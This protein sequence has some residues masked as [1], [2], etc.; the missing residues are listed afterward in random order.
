MKNI[1]IVIGF[2]ILLFIVWA[3]A[4]GPERF[5]NKGFFLSSPN[6]PR[7][8][9]LERS[10]RALSDTEGQFFAS[11]GEASPLQEKLFFSK[12]TTG[13]REIDPKDEYVIIEASRSNT[14]PV[15]IS[16]MRLS[17]PISGKNYPIPDGVITPNSNVVSSE[18]PI[19][20]NPGESAVIVSGQSPI[21]VSFRLNKCTGYLE[22]FQNFTPDLPRSCPR[23]EEELF[24]KQNVVQEFN[25]ECIDFIERLPRC[26]T[27]LGQLP[28]G[29]TN[30]CR[31]FI[32]NDLTYAG[33][34]ENHRSDSDFNVDEWRVYLGRN[35][36]LWR[37]KR[38]IIRLLDREGKVVDALTY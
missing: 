37:E 27:F 11:L 4:G 3:A 35:E 2:L 21:G 33:C 26:E 5:S 32:A 13:A 12:R 19:S 24:A 9:T 23:P 20:L 36:E 28:L 1:L 15:V 25:N 10:E 30:A 29:Y 22:N 38:E 16:G 8:L 17:S 7:I 31:Q 18:N 6:A 34:V 14:N